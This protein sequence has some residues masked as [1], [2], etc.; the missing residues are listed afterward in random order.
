MNSN[1]DS[2]PLR[3]LFRSSV[4]GTYVL[5]LAAIELI[6]C[7]GSEPNVYPVKG[8]V[9]FA[10]KPLPYGT[11]TFFG[12]RGKFDGV[13]EIDANGNYQLQVPPGK[14]TVGVYAHPGYEN[15]SGSALYKGGIA[16]GAKPLPGPVVPEKYNHFA[17]SPL[18]YEATVS[19]ENTFDITLP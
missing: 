1:Y 11:V 4:W 3:K 14:Y 15:P 13:A 7:G 10:G 6:G 16:P 12:P 19:A 17:S 8:R 18:S 2:I 9:V 5:G